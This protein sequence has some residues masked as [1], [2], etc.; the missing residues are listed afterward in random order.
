[1]AAVDDDEFLDEEPADVFI[2]FPPEVQNAIEQVR[3]YSALYTEVTIIWKCS[4]VMF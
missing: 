4:D 3:K 1:M 2:S